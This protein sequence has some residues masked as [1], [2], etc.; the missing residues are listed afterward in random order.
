MSIYCFQ[1]MNNFEFEVGRAY[2]AIDKQTGDLYFSSLIY[3]GTLIWNHKLCLHF[4]D[5][6]MSNLKVYSSKE[7]ENLYFFEVK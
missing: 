5:K 1:Y 4:Q 3:V 7:I 2:K 6:V